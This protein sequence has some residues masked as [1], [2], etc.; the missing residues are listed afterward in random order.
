MGYG[1]RAKFFNFPKMTFMAISTARFRFSQSIARE[2]TSI[3]L[4]VTTTVLVSILAVARKRQWLESSASA[5]S[6]S[7]EELNIF[8]N[9]FSS[10]VIH[11][12]RSFA[13]SYIHIHCIYMLSYTHHFSIILVCFNKF[14]ILKAWTCWR[15]CRMLF[16]RLRAR[17][18]RHHNQREI[19]HSRGF[20]RFS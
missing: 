8:V 6:K 1:L 15:S 12:T 11:S 16:T 2:V 5:G 13:L 9:A 19:S 10:S 4:L 20:E 3:A 14:I 17:V 18:V 7:D